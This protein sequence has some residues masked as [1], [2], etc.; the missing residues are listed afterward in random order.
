MG[1]SSEKQSIVVKVVRN[2]ATKAT[3]KIAW[4]QKLLKDLSYVYL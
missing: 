1:Q 3:Y 2:G 4:V